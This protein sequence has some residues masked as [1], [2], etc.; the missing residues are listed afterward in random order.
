MTRREN[1]LQ[2]YGEVWLMSSARCK[3]DLQGFQMKVVVKS[4][5]FQ[6]QGQALTLCIYWYHLKWSQY[7]TIPY[8]L[9]V[10]CYG[11]KRKLIT[12]AWRSL[13][14]EQCVTQKK[15]LRGFQMKVA[16]KSTHFQPQGRALTLCKCQML[17]PLEC[18]QHHTISIKC[19][20]LLR[21]EKSQYGEV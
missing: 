17:I 19:L 3:K 15:G 11:E 8:L 18:S 1:S 10:S 6:T 12:T 14:D 16:V 20:L 7:H 4:T 2:Q 13:A 21:D 9:N 5:H